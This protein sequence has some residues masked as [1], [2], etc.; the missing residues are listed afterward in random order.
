MRVTMDASHSPCAIPSFSGLSSMHNPIRSHLLRASSLATSLAAVLATSA[1]LTGCGGSDKP[2]ASTCPNNQ[3]AT[4]APSVLAQ[5]WGDLPYFLNVTGRCA[6]P[7]PADTINPL[8]G[9]RYDDKPGS[10]DIEKSWL[11]AWT[12]QTY[13]WYNEI[14]AVDPAPYVPGATVPY[15]STTTNAW[16]TVTLTDT[17]SVVDAY[18]NALRTWSF[19]SPKV[20]KDRFHFTYRTSDWVALTQKGQNIGYGMDLVLLA[21]AP[22]RQ[23]VVSNV[24]AGTSAALA[25]IARGAIISSVG[26]VDVI[27]GSDVNTINEALFHPVEGKTYQLGILDHGA[28]EVRQVSLR[29]SAQTLSPVQYVRTLPGSYSHVGY[30]LF[31]EHIATAEAQLISAIQTLKASNGGQ[32]VSDLVLDIRYNGGGILDVAS[33]LAYM[34][35]GPAATSNKNFDT[36]TFNDK[37]P[38]GYAQ[39]SIPF[40]DTALGYS[41]PRGLPLPQL[42]LSR[43]YVLTGAGTCSASEA[44]INGLRGVG[45]QVVQIGNTTCGKPFGFYA[46]E[47]CG[48]TYFAVNFKGVNQ[49]GFGDFD[50]G[51]QPDPNGGDN[52]ARV[53][54]CVVADDFNHDLG[55]LDE[56][57]LNAALTLRD[58][59]FC[60][61]NP[62]SRRANLGSHETLQLPREPGRN[63]ALIWR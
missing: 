36:L 60:P 23:I 32:G 51:F 46:T 35:A 45:I 22:P 13:L 17:Y 42:N 7:R 62:V 21:S 49:R 38:Y 24:S 41:A 1:V 26:P 61:A 31:N 48:T 19:N 25:G 53:P 8:T 54:G 18:F 39:I 37:S 63:N 27:N 50:S 56:A 59:G 58:R 11:Q 52:G 20:P 40:R 43:V 29:A 3:C 15:A 55:T 16:H 10:L 30:L 47:N 14:P 33:E 9:Y 12:N 44:I 34:I 28:T 4:A 5:G 2:Q 57:R 6:N